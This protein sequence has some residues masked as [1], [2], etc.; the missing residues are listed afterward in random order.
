[1]WRKANCIIYHQNRIHSMWTVATLFGRN[2]ARM[3]L[4]DSP[5]SQYIGLAQSVPLAPPANFR[6]MYFLYNIRMAIFLH[7]YYERS[8]IEWIWK[9]KA[10]EQS[11]MISFE[12]KNNSDELNVCTQTNRSSKF[13]VIFA[14]RC[15]GCDG[16][17]FADCNIWYDLHRRKLH[18]RVIIQIE[19]DSRL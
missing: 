16:F 2:P 5:R 8:T 15:I 10:K 12:Q 13:W 4:S 14:L 18:A 9:F 1:M 7:R 19:T 17:A 3:D 11:I 6:S